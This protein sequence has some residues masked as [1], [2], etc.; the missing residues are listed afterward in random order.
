M[1]YAGAGPHASYFTAG[2]Y[3]A[4]LELPFLSPLVRL[5]EKQHEIWHRRLRQYEGPEPLSGQGA[6][7]NIF[8]IPFVDYARGD[9][10]SIGPG[11]EKEWAQPHV[12]CPVIAAM[13]L[14]Y[15][16]F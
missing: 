10:L 13:I 1:I 5:V 16:F 4:E 8:R 6:A 9:G 14:L 7:A 12:L 2:E 15:E 3:L 11:Q